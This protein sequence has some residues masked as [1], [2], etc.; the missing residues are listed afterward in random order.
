MARISELRTAFAP[1][2]RP[3]PAPSTATLTPGTATAGSNFASLLG[4]QSA[5][6]LV[7]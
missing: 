4:A 5:S 2:V 6:P 1:P 3:A 7:L